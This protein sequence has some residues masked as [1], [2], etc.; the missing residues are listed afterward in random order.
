MDA[1]R[2]EKIHKSDMEIYKCFLR[3]LAL[4][5]NGLDMDRYLSIEITQKVKILEAIV[6][7]IVVWVMINW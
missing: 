3:T 1:I 4:C 6:K 5:H 2:E 7:K